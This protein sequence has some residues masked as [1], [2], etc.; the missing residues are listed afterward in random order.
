M[1]EKGITMATDAWSKH[2]HHD[3]WTDAWSKREL[4]DEW[5]VSHWETSSWCSSHWEA[6]GWNKVDE[7]SHN[8]ERQQWLNH[9]FF[10]TMDVDQLISSL[11]R[12]EEDVTTFTGLEVDP[13]ESRARHCC[14]EWSHRLS[15][16]SKGRRGSLSQV[17][18]Q[19]S[20]H[21]WRQPGSGHWR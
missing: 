3:N 17:E 14:T 13:G 12:G 2:H 11:C 19:T 15:S 9:A 16:I 8:R 4:G 21:P 18:A 1:P 5:H 20:C 10:E 6:S 7:R